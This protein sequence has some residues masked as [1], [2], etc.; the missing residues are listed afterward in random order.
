MALG[1]RR[2]SSAKKYLK[3]LG[4]EAEITHSSMGEELATG[5]DEAGWSKDRRVDLRQR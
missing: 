1:D 4:V 3:S 5:A 2:A